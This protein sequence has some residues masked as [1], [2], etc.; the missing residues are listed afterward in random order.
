MNATSFKICTTANT[1]TH[2][3]SV[4]TLPR[5]HKKWP[6]PDQGPFLK[7]I[8]SLHQNQNHPVAGYKVSRSALPRSLHY[9]LHT[10]AVKPSG[11][12]FVNI[13]SPEENLLETYFVLLSKFSFD[14]AK[15]QCVSISD[16]DWLKFWT[17]TQ[18]KYF[19]RL[20]Q[21]ESKSKSGGNFNQGIWGYLFPLW[22]SYI[23]EVF[24]FRE[25]RESTH[26]LYGN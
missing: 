17:S 10:T 26:P 18:A 25:F 6:L 15:E 2:H 16:H 1:S 23:F 14:R 5:P 11:S 3:T 20:N 24:I 9:T 19:I 22:I 8:T 7:G 13:G 4:T 12:E 21:H